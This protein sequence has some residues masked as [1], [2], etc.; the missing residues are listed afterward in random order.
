M[1]WSIA[2]KN[3]WRNHKRS[4]IV[5]VAVML[6]TGSGVFTSG[7][8]VGWVDQRIRSLVHIEVGHIKLHNPNYLNNEE[9]GYT[10]PDSRAISQSLSSNPTIKGFSPRIKVMAMAST[11]R[12]NTALTLQGIDVTQEKQISELYTHVLPG[13]TFLET[14]GE[15]SIVISDKT[16]EQL[17]IK[18][19]TLTEIAL[20][21]LLSLSVPASVVDGLRDLSQVRFNTEKAFTKAVSQ[22]LNPKQVKKYGAGIVT[23]AKHYRL[24]SKIVFTLT[25]VNGE[26][27]S[28]SFR[29][30]GIF[31]TDNL[32]FDQTNAYVLKNELALLTGLT[33]DDCHEIG[34]LLYD[35]V[36]VEP[37]QAAIKQVFPALSVMN[38]LEISP[39]AGMLTKYMDLYYYIIMGFI[40]FALAF[41]IINTMLMAILERTKELGMLMA[42]GMS[43]KRIF[44]MI[45]L[46]TIFLT[47]VGAVLGMA[48][49]WLAITITGHTGLDFSVVG[50]GFEA[51]GWS[52]L[53]YPSITPD[54][55]F[56]VTLLVIATGILSS[57]LPARKA[58][59]LNPV[60][61]IK[62]DN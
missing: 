38:W 20:D 47:L 52:A 10:L 39:D 12:G 19:Y 33:P 28:Q 11:S 58:L 42:I 2:W 50:E 44:Y 26:M 16:A 25:D 57:I 55:F 1:I 22:R 7:L 34:I 21:S 3:V 48:F 40:L 32:L 35:E 27:V 59:S 13:G 51:M 54:F 18:N 53:V 9:I 41:G 62:S 60:D 61:A 17:R 23:L 46:E 56:G 49:G 15:N 37:T 30:C 5:I 31:K 36:A 14:T 29:V 4:I 45:M 43:R 8:M 6:G 24:R